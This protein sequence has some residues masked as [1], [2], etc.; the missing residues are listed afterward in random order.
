MDVENANVININTPK[1]SQP[2][3][4]PYKNSIK[5]NAVF[6]LTNQNYNMKLNTTTVMNHLNANIDEMSSMSSDRDTASEHEQYDLKMNCFD[7]NKFSPPPDWTNRL[8]ERI[9][10]YCEQKM[11]FNRKIV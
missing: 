6:Y 4:I 2:I 11:S 7:P 3:S 9:E 10:N 1:C 8:L 5:S